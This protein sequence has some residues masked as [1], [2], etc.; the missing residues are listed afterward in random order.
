MIGGFLN[1]WLALGV[2]L[3]SVPL[4]IHLLNRQR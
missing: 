1:G 2:G 3:A 4:I